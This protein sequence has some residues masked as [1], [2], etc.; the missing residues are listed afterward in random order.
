M[1]LCLTALDEHQQERRF[2]CFLYELEVVFEFLNHII[3]EGHTLKEVVIIEKGK[4]RS[5]PVDAFDGVSVSPAFEQLEQEWS[6]ILAAP[7]QPVIA[8]EP[9]D[10]RWCREQLAFYEQRI[11]Q[12]ELMVTDMNRLY[13]RAE[14]SLKISRNPYQSVLKCYESQLIQAYLFRKEILAHL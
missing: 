12:L 2:S 7:L 5:L 14:D 4:T 3:V 10:I 11:I 13:Q 6:A 1:L 9:K 8:S